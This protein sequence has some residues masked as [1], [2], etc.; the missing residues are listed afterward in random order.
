MICQFLENNV[1][2]QYMEKN[3]LTYAELYSSPECL[4][5]HSEAMN[6][7]SCIL[8]LPHDYYLQAELFGVR[9]LGYDDTTFLHPEHLDYDK[10]LP[11][12]DIENKRLQTV[13]EALQMARHDGYT[14][15]FNLSG[16]A[17]LFA[18][19]YGSTLFYTEWYSGSDYIPRLFSCM[20]DCLLELTK[21]ARKYGIKLFSFAESTLLLPLV[22]P[23]FAGE[24]SDRILY[25]FLKKL[26]DRSG[27]MVFHMCRLT[28]ELM[29]AG[30][31]VELKEHLTEEPAPYDQVLAHLVD[32]TSSTMMIGDGCIHDLRTV[33]RYYELVLCS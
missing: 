24:Y 23:A 27:E 4:L 18:A 3:Q 16:F 29:L 31:S 1:T 13:L 20:Q 12:Y 8:S 19:L 30:K 2:S 25:P 17:D 6:T 26:S 28:T 33:D 5:H 10:V 22:G 11:Y 9:L 14:P 15:C 7:A 21:K 32:T